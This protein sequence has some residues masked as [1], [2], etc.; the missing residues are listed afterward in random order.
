MR[1]DFEDLENVCHYGPKGK[2]LVSQL[3][4]AK[5]P[6]GGAILTVEPVKYFN[7]RK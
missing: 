4:V 3:A 6:T 5:I 7:G 2:T 1:P